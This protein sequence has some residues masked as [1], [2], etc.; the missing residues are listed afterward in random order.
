MIRCAQ[1]GACLQPVPSKQLA[2][3]CDHIASPR[4]EMPLKRCPDYSTTRY[5]MQTLHL[6]LQMLLTCC[7]TSSCRTSAGNSFPKQLDLPAAFRRPLLPARAAPATLQ[8]FTP[9]E[10][11]LRGLLKTRAACSNWYDVLPTRSRS[12]ARR[13]SRYPLGCAST[14]KSLKQ[15]PDL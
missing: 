10:N 12:P 11:I 7:S 3:R 6:K 13:C 5:L 4:S 8:P 1:P 15:P 14:S 2:R 9:P